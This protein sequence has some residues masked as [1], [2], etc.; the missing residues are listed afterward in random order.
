MISILLLVSLLPLSAFGFMPASGRGVSRET[1]SLQVRL[2]VI[3]QVAKPI[4]AEDSA[5]RR[6]RYTEVSRKYRRTTYDQDQ[7]LKHR[8]SDRFLENL[9]TLLDSGVVRALQK[10]VSLIGG[11]AVFVVVWNALLVAGYDDFGGTHHSPIVNYALPLVSLP[12]QPFSLS[13]ASL[14]LLLGTY[15]NVLYHRIARVAITSK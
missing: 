3:T 9:T 13:N 12:I 5:R 15:R 8:R 14:G 1:K 11:T 4:S 10:E 7:W 2:N 6:A